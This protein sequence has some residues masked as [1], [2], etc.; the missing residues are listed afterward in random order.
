M[1]PNRRRGPRSLR[2]APHVFVALALALLP[3]HV[4][5]S[6]S[7]AAPAAPGSSA[8]ASATPDPLVHDELLAEEDGGGRAAAG[9]PGPR[10]W[11]RDATDTTPSH[12]YLWCREKAVGSKDPRDADGIIMTKYEWR[13]TPVYN[14]TNI[15]LQ[16]LHWYEAWLHSGSEVALLDFLKHARWLRDKGMDSQ[17]RFPY[18]WYHPERRLRAPW[19]SAMAQG[20][21][22][23]VLTRA[24]AHTKDPSFLQAAERAVAPFTKD[25]S[26]GGVVTEGGKWLEEYP[27]GYHVL[28]GSVFALWGLWD[29]KRTC[30]DVTA[31][32][33]WDKAVANLRD[34]LSRYE[35]HGAI[36]YELRED[37]FAFPD[38]Y[39]LQNRQLDALAVLAQE[40]RFSATASRW[41]KSFRA[42][43]A[44]EIAVRSAY[45]TS[46]GSSLTIRGTVNY[47]FAYYPRS[48]SIRLWSK[49]L[50][51]SAPA[52][53]VGGLPVTRRASPFYTGD[54]TYAT[55]L[56]TR[57]TRYEFTVNGQPSGAP[58]GYR[59]EQTTWAKSDVILPIPSVSEHRFVNNP[60][61]P[62]GDGWADWGYAAYRI[63][64]AAA[65]VNLRVYDGAWRLKRT[66]PGKVAGGKAV[67]QSPGV[68]WTRYD[69]KDSSGR[70]LPNGIYHY[71]VTAWNANGERSRSGRFFISNDL[72][73]AP[74][75]G[76]APRLSGVWV[77][78]NPFSPNGDGVDEHQHFCFTL[79]QDAYVTIKV[80]SSA[81]EVRTV[82]RN[83]K[84]KAGRHY[85][86]WKGEDA[87]GK[88]L[89]AGNYVYY[90]YASSGGST[91][92]T[93]LRTGVTGVRR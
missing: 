65:N 3:L 53:L 26:A 9:F 93:A 56:L 67:V 66:V 30:G 80:F 79:S 39:D 68:H 92:R 31:A 69:L 40:P 58:A 25:V 60:A 77:D 29:L 74:S 15:A 50:G 14:P 16:S 19:Y 45:F 72:R 10:E 73:V 11:S 87:S 23:S 24:Y 7:S 17:G 89:P 20:A 64:G 32:A 62:N 54:F 59:Y 76:T 8:P 21:G 81:R 47:L 88:L 2:C 33:V 55:P 13:S 6:P 44:P 34:R 18:A 90:V 85:P 28:N 83:V 61:T 42:Y 49:R 4:L 22:I 5:T 51:S 78:P 46:K 75:L 27:D 57:D 36:L 84:L 37:H 41:R 82:M 12:Y 86:L 35:S 38:Y 91:P 1:C 71:K 48:T 63:G 43:P 52:V 70:L